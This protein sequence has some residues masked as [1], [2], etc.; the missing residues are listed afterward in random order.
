MI[1]RY[2]SP[3]TTGIFLCLT[4]IFPLACTESSDNDLEGKNILE[5][6]RKI[7]AEKAEQE[8]EEIKKQQEA[9]ARIREIALRNLINM[10]AYQIKDFEKE[11]QEEN[12]FDP[13]QTLVDIVYSQIVLPSASKEI[14]ASRSQ[15]IQNTVNHDKFDHKASY[16]RINK[17]VEEYNELPLIK[18]PLIKLILDA[19][20]EKVSSSWE[21]CTDSTT[22][23]TYFYNRILDKR[24]SNPEDKKKTRQFLLERV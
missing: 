3:F 22:K 9:L 15:L 11:L 7:A 1:T 20:A 12:D 5:Q 8:A 10:Q 21:K 16:R 4:M 24:V 2:L 23:E 19:I 14:K 17:M 18:L 13:N 6:K